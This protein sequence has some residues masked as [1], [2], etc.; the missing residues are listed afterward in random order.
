MMSTIETVVFT[1]PTVYYAARSGNG[2]YTDD[3]QTL[4]T[5]SSYPQAVVYSSEV[6]PT[7]CYKMATVPPATS[8]KMDTLTNITSLPS[9]IYENSTVTFENDTNSY[10]TVDIDQ[11]KIISINNWC[12][13]NPFILNSVTQTQT[14][15][16]IKGQVSK[17]ISII[18]FSATLNCGS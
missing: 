3:L 14:N 9:S 15:F 1:S 4:K 11:S 7:S 5:F 18:P 8:K 6:T 12:K 17:L 10:T 16:S 2:F 13:Q